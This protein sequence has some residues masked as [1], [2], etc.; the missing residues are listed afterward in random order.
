MESVEGH[1]AQLL[2]LQKPWEVV[3]VELPLDTKRV[4]IH[5]EADLK[6]AE[7]WMLKENMRHF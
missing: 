1:Y 7:A 3:E 4:E 2:G 6:T 5:L